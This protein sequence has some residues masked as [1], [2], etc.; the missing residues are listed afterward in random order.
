MPR[1]AAQ[2][3][4]GLPVVLLD[5]V[6]EIVDFLKAALVAQ[7]GHELDDEI[8]AIDVLIEIKDVGLN[9]PPVIVE[10]GAHTHIGHGGITL[11]AQDGK[12]GIDAIGR[13][14]PL[15]ADI[16]VGRG[17]A[18]ALA[19]PCAQDDFARQPRIA[20]EQLGSVLHAPVTQ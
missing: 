8:T 18:Q 12:H 1:A 4:P 5:L 6:D 3:L 19:S 9:G 17:K 7:P 11:C 16:Q 2:D 13:Y 10:T 20:P 15:G 14:G